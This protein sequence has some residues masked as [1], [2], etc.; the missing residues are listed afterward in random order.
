MHSASFHVDLGPASVLLDCGP[1]TLHGFDAFSVAWTTLTHIAITH[2][3][4]DHVGD[5]A[6]IM[7][8]LK[9][10][11]RPRRTVPLTLIGPVGIRTFLE[12][13]A[14]ALGD[15]VLRP[16]FDVRVVEMEPGQTFRE[17][18]AEFELGCQVTR[19]TA[20]SLAYRLGGAW[21]G[22]GYTGDTGP[23]DELPA[24]FDECTVLVAECAIPDP[25]SQDNHLSPSGLA[26]LARVANPE[27][28]LVSHVYPPRTPEEAAA[29]VRDLWEGEV[30]AARDGLRIAL[31]PAGPSVDP[32]RALI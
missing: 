13:L 7:F 20:P 31:R 9:N 1:G 26:A 17:P 21:G 25:P 10:A 24:F 5:L 15:H 8:S 3:H 6:A 16:G 22:I 14:A 23:S 29:S 28:L 32:L 27:L 19:H 4:T 11:V 30:L 18:E 12:R 2:F